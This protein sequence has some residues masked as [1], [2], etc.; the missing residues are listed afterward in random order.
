LVKAREIALKQKRAELS[1]DDHECQLQ[2]SE[3]QKDLIALENEISIEK[4]NLAHKQQTR[5][6]FLV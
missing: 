5:D 3:I 4:T 1:M 6:D 2:L